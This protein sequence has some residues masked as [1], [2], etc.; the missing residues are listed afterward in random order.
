MGV[1]GSL[2]SLGPGMTGQTQSMVINECH[3]SS[4]D[5]ILDLTSARQVTRQGR[6]SGFS[7][8]PGSEHC[9]PGSQFQVLH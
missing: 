7:R 3:G 8:T 5:Y 2:L 6:G 1:R 9:S 4:C